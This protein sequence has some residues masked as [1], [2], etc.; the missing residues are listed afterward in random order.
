MVWNR[1]RQLELHST[2]SLFFRS[3]S[4][5]VIYI[6]KFNDMLTK[7]CQCILFEPGEDKSHLH[8]ISL[9]HTMS[10]TIPFQL[11]SSQFIRQF[12]SIHSSSIIPSTRHLKQCLISRYPDQDLVDIFHFFIPFHPYWFHQPND[13]GEGQKNSLRSSFSLFSFLLLLPLFQTHIF[14]S[15][16]RSELFS[17]CFCSS[18]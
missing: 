3:C 8:N 16:S 15:A 17:H 14:S 10:Y 12:S 11:G 18:W 4:P 7:A 1:L 2:W 9:Q 5:T 13:F 6:P